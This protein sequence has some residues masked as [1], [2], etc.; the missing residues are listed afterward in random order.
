MNF[1]DKRL[2]GGVSA[3]VLVA[4]VGGFSIARLTSPSAPAAAAQEAKKDEPLKGE[5]ATDS[6]AMTAD[7]IK[8]AGIETGMVNAGGLGAE[9]VAQGTVTASPNGEAMVTARAGGAV[10]RVF[11]RLGDSVR[12]GEPLAIVESRD[13]AQ[14]AS[15]RTVANARAELA[16]NNLERE[17]YL[18]RERVSARVDLERAEADYAAAQAEVRRAQVSAGA[19]RV[20]SDGR[21]VIVTSPISGRVTAASITLGAYVQPET[22]LFRVADPRLI[23]VEAAVGSVDAGRVAP[24]DTA[25]VEMP[26]GRTVNARV[27]AVTPTL[28]GE[29]RAATAVLDV[30]GGELQPGL[31][32]R[33]R[34][35][36]S[37][38]ETSSAIVVPEEAVQS[39]EGR[40]VVFVRNAAGF[41]AVP[42]SLGRRSAGRVEVLTGLSGGQTIATRQAFLLK[43]EL[44]KGTGE[45]E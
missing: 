36:P 10:I 12:A 35:K 23:Q 2:L 45:E 22:E 5:A 25:V 6:V 1:N 34:L 28:N 33:V 38:G 40:D 30:D 13:A 19:A 26:N 17:R 18:I 39:V 9:I 41:R 43:A 14:L 3:A 16:R 15:E 27:R 20:T 42:V 4:A 8:A 31:A 29:T 11:K 44:S 21:G 24:G 37:R 7:A 32:V